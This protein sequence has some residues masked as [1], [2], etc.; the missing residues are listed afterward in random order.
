[1]ESILEQSWAYQEM[2]SR[3]FNKGFNKGF[4]EGHNKGFDEG[5][6]KGFD[7]GHN[8][9]FDEGHNKGFDE[10]HN[11]GFDEGHNKGFDEGHNK[12]FDEGHN[13]GFD[14]ALV[15]F[16]RKRF[17]KQVELADLVCAQV[18]DMAVLST[19]FDS[20]IEANSE[21]EAH[22]ILTKALQSAS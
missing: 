14:E 15:R 5:H 9:G 22:E 4:D 21:E 8:K 1:M 11:K 6:N 12:G 10:G 2:V 7:E 16:V 18:T 17:P 13:K 20:L 3:G 19:T